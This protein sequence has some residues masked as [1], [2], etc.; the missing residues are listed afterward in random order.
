MSDDAV[1]VAPEVYA[2]LFENDR[3]RVLEVRADPGGTSPMHTHPDSVIH[4]LSDATLVVTSQQG[5]ARPAEARTAEVTAGA[6]WWAAE[7]THS[8]E[9]VGTEEVHFIRVELK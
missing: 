1:F 3:V 8:V 9:N 7:T 4:A 6:T 5:E 2:V